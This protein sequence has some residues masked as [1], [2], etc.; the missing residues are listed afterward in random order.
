MNNRFIDKDSLSLKDPARIL[1]YVGIVP[2]GIA[3]PLS[4]AE[5]NKL[6]RERNLGTFKRDMNELTAPSQL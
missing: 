3:Q 5:K 4:Q 6:W 1:P 2:E